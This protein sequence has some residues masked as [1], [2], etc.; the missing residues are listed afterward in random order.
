MSTPASRR[1]PRR[2]SAVTPAEPPPEPPPRPARG[3]TCRRRD[4]RRARPRRAHP[5]VAVL[6]RPAFVVVI[7]RRDGAAARRELCRALRAGRPRRR[8]CRCWSARCG[9]GRA[10]L[11]RGD[12][13]A[14]CIAFAADR[15][16]PSCVW[17]LARRPAGYLPRHRA[18]RCCVAAV[19]AAAGRV[20]RAAARPRTTAPR[21]VIA[22]HRDRRLQRRRRLRGRR[23]F[24]KH[25]M[26]PTDQPEEV[27][28]GLRRAR[29]LTCCSAGGADRRR[30]LPRRVVA[31]PAVRAGD[32]R[33][34]DPRRPR[35]VAGQARPRHQGHGHLLPGHGGI[36]DRL[37]SLL[38]SAAVAFLLLQRAGAEL[39]PSTVTER[40][41]DDRARIA[42]GYR[43][44]A[45]V[46]A[47]VVSPLYAELASAVAGDDD[48]LA[49]LAAMPTGK[50]QP[51]LLL[52]ALRFLHGRPPDD[53]V[54]L[55]AWVLGDAD[56][57]RITML[58][59]A[60]QTNEPARCA[61]LLP[62]LAALPQPLALVEVGC[63]AGL[64]LLPR[65]L[66]PTTT[67]AWR[68]ARAA[69]STSAARPAAV[70]RFPARCPG[71]RRAS[72]STCT[73]WTPPTPTTWSGCGRSSGPGRPLPS[74]W[75]ASTPPRRSPCAIR[76]GCSPET[77]SS[78]C[79][80][81]WTACPPA[82]PPW[83]CTPRC[84]PT[85][86][87]SGGRRSPRWSAER[88]A[89]D[90]PGGTGAA[91]G[92]RRAAARPARRAR[93]LRAVAGRPPAGLGRAPRR[94]AGLVRR[95]ARV[96]DASD[97]GRCR[98]RR[99]GGARSAS[100]RGR[101][102]GPTT[103]ATTRS[104]WP[105][106]TGATW[107]TATATGRVEAIVADLDPRRHPFHVAIENFGARLQHRHR[108]AHR[109]R[110]PGR[111]GAH[112][113]PPALE[114]ARRDGHRPLP[115]RPAPPG[116][117]RAGRLRREAG[118]AADRHRQPARAP[119]DRDRRAAAAAACCCSARRARV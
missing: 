89:V 2:S 114:P 81:P 19:R 49:F 54:Q 46:E 21:R 92:R 113:R 62:V 116:R 17:R 75:P 35:R 58:S 80:P 56:R 73:R 79:P 29:S 52:A 42:R 51:N 87:G 20:R 63:S 8:W 12:R 109:Q 23:L 94:P 112:R 43:S 96:S 22:V 78:S 83:S 24:G 103:R 68:S 31:G 100:G 26:A 98:G 53:G 37:D 60:T 10:G 115:A 25:P 44:F 107:S 27:L 84:C 13:R 30:C 33:D 77:S 71:W 57:L 117:R 97:R 5:A 11:D 6:Y 67:T 102:R 48:V 40:T 50:R 45:E 72:A 16:S 59:R 36:M 28:G 101:A 7:A 106:A 82:R 14:W 108:R 47:A 88:R 110:L 61:A 86:R 55:R 118:S 4:R 111:R 32:R 74:G 64:C 69:A 65:P 38:P 39:A 90:R 85:C 93:P 95:A 9:D 3:A 70:S 104:C 66:R 1:R 18:P 119:A 91:P 105:R 76:C 34:G 99:S 15:C 41:P